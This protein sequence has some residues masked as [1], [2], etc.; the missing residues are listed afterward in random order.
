MTEQ[1]YL[2]IRSL[3][4]LMNAQEILSHVASYSIPVIDHKKFVRLVRE[5]DRMTMKLFDAIHVQ[6]D[7][8]T[9]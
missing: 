8:T 3:S 4:A 7:T 9:N 6:E 5:L 2:N 1:E